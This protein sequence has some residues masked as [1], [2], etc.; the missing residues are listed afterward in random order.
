MHRS[1]YWSAAS[2][3]EDLAAVQCPVYAIGGWPSGNIKHTRCPLTRGH[4]RLPSDGDAEEERRGFE[5]QLVQLPL[6]VGLSAG[7]WCS[8]TAAPD[9]R[10]DKRGVN[11]L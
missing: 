8:Y 2:V 7:K 10:E 4:I 1:A 6:S 3:C 5:E 9:L 11:G